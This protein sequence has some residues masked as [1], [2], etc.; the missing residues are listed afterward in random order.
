MDMRR[1]Q[2]FFFFFYLT[3]LLPGAA[4]AQTPVDF[5]GEWHLNAKRCDFGPM[6]N[7][8]DETIVIKQAAATMDMQRT[9]VP[10]GMEPQVNAEQ[11]PLD[12]S[13]AETREPHEPIVRRKSLWSQ[14]RHALTITREV[15]YSPFASPNVFVTV[16]TLTLI[17]DGK[18]LRIESHA[19]GPDFKRDV[20]LIYDRL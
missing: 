10:D 12:G 15:D 1:R 11:F 3:L 17:E 5:S 8:G 19:T 7:P 13:V 9:L 14:E 6:G 18:A 4:F 2:F 20:V 16:E